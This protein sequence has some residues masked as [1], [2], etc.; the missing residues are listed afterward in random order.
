MDGKAGTGRPRKWWLDWTDEMLK[1]MKIQ[2]YEVVWAKE[3]KWRGECGRK[4]GG[5]MQIY[6]GKVVA[7][8]QSATKSLCNQCLYYNYLFSIAQYK[9]F[10]GCAIAAVKQLLPC[11]T[12]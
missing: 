5:G 7:C 9:Q 8:R 2:K 3:M 6:M 11:W 4:N 12:W 10:P 1:R